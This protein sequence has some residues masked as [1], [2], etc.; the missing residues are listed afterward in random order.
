MKIE[1]NKPSLFAF[2]I[3]LLIALATAAF[4]AAPYLLAVTLGLILA[5]L[6]NPV[7]NYFKKKVNPHLSA[8]ITVL[9]VLIIVVGPLSILSIVSVKQAAI[10]EQV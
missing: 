6:T 5:V 3:V 10:L 4:M 1:K 7:Y 8:L 2:E 9:L